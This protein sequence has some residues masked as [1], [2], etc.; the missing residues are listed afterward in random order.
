M[1]SKYRLG[2]N[3]QLNISI[4]EKKISKTLIIQKMLRRPILNRF[5]RTSS[6]F[7]GPGLEDFVSGDVQEKNYSEYSG[8]LKR[9]IG[10]KRLRL[11]PWLKGNPTA[12]VF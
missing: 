3:I 12:T 5:Q 7:N 8:K 9:E 11:P 6:Q 1:R 4:Y 2:I 10:D